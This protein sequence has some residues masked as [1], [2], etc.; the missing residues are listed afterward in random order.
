MTSL[1]TNPNQIVLQTT[2]LG[3]VNE[4]CDAGSVDATLTLTDD[5]GQIL[6]VIRNPGGTPRVYDCQNQE[7]GWILLD[8]QEQANVNVS[9]RLRTWESETLLPQAYVRTSEQL[10]DSI[11]IRG[12]NGE[13]IASIQTIDASNGASAQCTSPSWRL[14]TYDLPQPF[15]ANF[16]QTIVMFVA[17]QSIAPYNKMNSCYQQRTASNPPEG[18]PSYYEPALITLSVTTGLVVTATLI[19]G[20]IYLHRLRN[21]V[22]TVQ[23]AGYHV[24]D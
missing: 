11:T 18:R 15:S 8:E 24:E 12:I 13:V 22:T 3:T 9:T 4:S 5:S 7:I 2:P 10:G 23:A 16:A 17:M 21:P 14:T 6:A 20:G 1:C 19:T